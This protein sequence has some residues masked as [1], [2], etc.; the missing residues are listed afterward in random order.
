M[1][2]LLSVGFIM[3]LSIVLIACSDG[4]ENNESTNEAEVVSVEVTE[5]AL[6]DLVVSRH[7]TGRVG[8]RNQDPLMLSGPAEVEEV[9]VKNGDTVEEDDDIVTVKTEM[10]EQVLKA[11]ADG[12]VAQFTARKGNTLSG[13]DPV[14]IIVDL[15]EMEA[16]FQMSRQTRDLLK[17]DDKVNIFHGDD[18]ISATVDP[19]E[20]LPNDAGQFDVVVTFNNEKTKLAAG[21]VV[22]L[23]VVEDRVKDTLVIPTDALL[24]EDDQSY[25]FV[26]DGSKA[27]RVDVEVI[28]LQSDLVAVEGDLEE[29]DEIVVRGQFLLEDGTE[30]T[31]E[32]EGN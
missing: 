10:G 4:N 2:R 16:Q 26:V 15:E 23:E 31:V 29:A 30:V 3:L 14:A 24:T 6:D 22:K 19:L 28:E 13:E 17:A 32:K 20:V 18:K 9:H 5:I 11:P 7:I 12:V 27:K 21:D 1:K 25:V 8:V